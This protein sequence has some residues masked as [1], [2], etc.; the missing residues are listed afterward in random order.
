MAERSEDGRHG[1]NGSDGAL[2]PDKD[3]GGVRTG[4]VRTPVP[5]KVLG[6]DNRMT[7]GARRV[8]RSLIGGSGGG[9]N[10]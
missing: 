2:L 10:H 3:G 7:H 8:Q 4:A 9:D 6:T 1:K 5:L